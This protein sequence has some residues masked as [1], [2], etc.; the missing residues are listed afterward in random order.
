M[1]VI[2]Q[3][4]YRTEFCTNISYYGFC[5][6]Y[7]CES[8][9]SEEELRINILAN[10]KFKTEL[11]RTVFFKKSF[12]RY[13][14]KCNFL[15]DKYLFS[16]DTKLQEEDEIVKATI[17]K[18]QETLFDATNGVLSFRKLVNIKLNTWHEEMIFNRLINP[19]GAINF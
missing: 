12:C 8:A 9:H 11:C 13:R 19:N 1:S 7:Y 10:K 16:S 3:K 17:I 2:V 14:Y 6:R 18:V 5:N 4:N 15:H